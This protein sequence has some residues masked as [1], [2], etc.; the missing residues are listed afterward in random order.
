MMSQAKRMERLRC[1]ACGDLIGVYEP[2]CAI[3]PDGSKRPGSRLSL[4]VELKQPSTVALHERCSGS[5]GD[6]PAQ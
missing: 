3:L 1:S 4:D 5:R 6:Q 2:I